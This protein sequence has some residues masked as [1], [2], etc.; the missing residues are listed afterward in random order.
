VNSS[1]LSAAW[2]I[3]L[4]LSLGSALAGTTWNGGGGSNTYWGTA[5]NWDNYTLPTFDESPTLTFGTG[6]TIATNET[7]RDIESIIFNR[8]ADFTIN[9]TGTV[10]LYSGITVGNTQ[11]AG[12]TYTIQAPVSLQYTSTWTINNGSSGINYLNIQSNIDG[13]GCQLTIEGAGTVQ[14][15]SPIQFTSLNELVGYSSTGT[16]TQTSGTNSCNF[17]CLGA[18]PEAS[19]TYNL[20][21]AGRLVAS[22]HEYIG[23]YGT[24]TFNQTGGINS[25]A[26]D[27]YLGFGPGSSGTYK[28]SGSGQ[29]SVLTENIGGHEE[30]GPGLFTQTSGTNTAKLVQIGATGTF[31]LKAGTLI[32]N[33]GLDNKGIFDLSASSAVI[34]MSSSIVNLSGNI[35]VTGQNTTLNIDAHS[36]LIVPS[37]HNAGEYF[38]NINNSG[39]IIHQAGFALD[40]APDHFI[41]G[42]GSIDDHVNCQGRLSATTGYAIRLN[43]GLS[44]IGAGN[45][46]L[47]DG[48]HV[49]GGVLIVNDAVSG[50][51]AGT[52]HAF[53]QHVGYQGV[54][55]FT[56]SGGSN[57][58]SSLYIGTYSSSNGTYNLNDTG[59]L[60][61]TS[62]EYIGYTGTGTFTQTGGTNTTSLNLYLGY[63]AGISGTYNLS[64]ASQLSVQT[65]YIG[66]SGTGTFT[67]TGGINTISSSSYLYLGYNSGSS[68]TYNLNGG[69]LITKSISKGSGAATFNFGGGTLQ[70]SGSFS[71]TLPM[72]L[73]GE[74][75]DANVDTLGYIVTLS[76]L[77]S[78]AG[79]L[80]KL[81]AGTLEF[82]KGIEVS[83]TTVLN[84]QAGKAV[85]KTVNVNEIDL[86]IT[87]AALATFEVLNGVHEV[88]AIDGSGL[89]QVD[90]GAQLTASSIVQGK[91]TIRSGA[92]VT[93]RSLPGGPLS[94]AIT[95]VPEPSMLVLLIG[96]L[97]VLAF[98][99]LAA[100]RRMS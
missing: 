51:D 64:G 48:G 37:E 42:I 70:A 83:D 60:S 53:S 49:A 87:T 22:Y 34:N 61:V 91:L 89:T 10:N 95:A 93:I 1:I 18:N 77:I 6:G 4:A 43:G 35:L 19:G 44:I 54:G 9:G 68:G 20:S 76:D 55:T 66:R 25:I 33:G 80:N 12:R 7:E 40:I 73:T 56:Q 21:G 67:Q 85:L 72:T 16:F 45:V 36:L 57:T 98:K 78:G 39:G 79:G 46:N 27:L 74:G 11:T 62:N 97:A 2:A 50:M 3:I 84:V 69:T 28:L 5:A 24:G 41:Y 99:I 88:G 94:G 96:A 15:N 14:M 29:L 13:A 38:A 81:G 26:S 90:S 31:T 23:Q 32:I 82:T 17:L 30:L 71:T 65:E 52:L 63:N 75:G 86:N 47:G 58:S 100:C 92:K 59:Q 8:D